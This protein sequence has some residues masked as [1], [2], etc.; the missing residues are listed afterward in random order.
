MTNETL[1]IRAGSGLLISVLELTQLILF[2]QFNN[3]G[4]IN[5]EKNESV[6]E[7]KLSFKMLEQ[8]FS[9]KSD[10]GSYIVSIANTASKKIE[11]LIYSIKFPFPEVVLYH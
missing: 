1:W 11:A 7:E 6:L 9:Y 8:S 5:V 10:W 2:S 3:C 4:D